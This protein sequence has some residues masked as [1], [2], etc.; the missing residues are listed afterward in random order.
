MT[1]RDQITGALFEEWEAIDGVLADLDESQWRL[2][3]PLP[4]WDVH[5]V[6]AHII[7]TESFMRGVQPPPIDV[8]VA[9][10][11]HVKNPIAALNEQWVH[12][13]KPLTGAALLT[14]YRRVTDARRAELTSMSDDE[15]NAPTASPI[16]EVAYGRFVR[17]RLFDCWM[18]ELDIRDAV[19]KPGDEGGARGRLAFQ[20]IVDAI[21][22]VFAKRG[23]APDGSRIAVE[24]TGPLEQTLNV[25]VDGRAAVVESLDGPATT[26][27][28]MDS[29]VFTR[30]AG[31]RTTVAEHR[32]DVEISGDRELGQRLVDN[33]AFVF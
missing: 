30:L 5:A 18:H 14:E 2:P 9:A 26:T 4:G 24:L 17:V 21:A 8:D 31:G 1:T 25:A 20:D 6:V 7:G 23:K 27:L 29:G 10:L 15:W 11:P 13:L 3:T 33:L 22:R 32:D 19:D 16:G 28:R 12:A